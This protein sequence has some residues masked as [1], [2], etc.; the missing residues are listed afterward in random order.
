VG[1][2]YAPSG[3][4]RGR[5]LWETRTVSTP[6]ERARSLWNAFEQEGVEGLRPLVDDDVEWRPWGNHGRPLKGVEQIAE[7]HR[8]QR[9]T[10]GG[11][12]RTVYKWEGVGECALASGSL[13]VFR[14]GGF[15]DVQPTWA[16]FF[17][18]ER[19]ERATCYATREEALAAVEA[20]AA[21]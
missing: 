12:R 20:H 6:V 10:G 7:W 18:G 15:L 13:R 1:K 9:V 4:T 21:V 3:W 5:D 8:A 17:R 11:S 16:F 14:T 19:L 2:E